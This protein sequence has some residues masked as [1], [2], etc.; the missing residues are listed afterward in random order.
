[1][2]CIDSYCSSNQLYSLSFI[3][4]LLKL[5]G[6]MNLLTDRLVDSDMSVSVYGWRGVNIVTI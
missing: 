5:V 4:S 2:L 1:M 3:F 6:R